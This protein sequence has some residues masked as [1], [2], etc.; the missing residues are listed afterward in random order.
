MKVR[1]GSGLLPI[2]LLVIV[3]IGVITLFPSSTLQI[4]L[5]LPLVIF[6]PGY[7]LIA[8]LFPK[9]DSLDGIE[10]VGLSF[11]TSLAVVPLLGLLLNYTPWGIRIESVLYSVASFIFITSGSAWL[12]RRQLPEQEGFD[13][14]FRVRVPGL[15]GRGWDRALSILLILSILGVFGTLGYIMANPKAGEKYT[16]FY[17]LGLSGEATDYP[18][19]LIVWEEG[20]VIVGIINH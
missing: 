19:E 8:A 2:N 13:I 3:L 1:T 11:V 15:S 9:K 12:R 16:E 14:E 18:E 7:V 10:R 4:V 5:G 17:V 20:E 6:S